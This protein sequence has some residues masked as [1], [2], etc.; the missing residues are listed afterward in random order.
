[1]VVVSFAEHPIAPAQISKPEISGRKSAGPAPTGRGDKRPTPGPSKEGRK[2][3]PTPGP[4]K[5][6]R[7]K[8]PTPGPSKEGRKKEPTP[9]PS[10]EG[11]EGI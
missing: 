10:K 3:E 2:K 5:E 4:S 9:G 8:E 11:K 1:L 7:K 6:G